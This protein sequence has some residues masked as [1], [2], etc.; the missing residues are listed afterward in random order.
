VTVSCSGHCVAFM[1]LRNS[2]SFASEA[3]KENGRIAASSAAMV[4]P[5]ESRLTAPAAA[6]VASTPRREDVDDFLGHDHSP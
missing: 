2:V 1:R 5:A 6:E 4:G 3:W